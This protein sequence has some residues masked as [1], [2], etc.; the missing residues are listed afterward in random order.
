MKEAASE[1][2]EVIV[3][4][5]SESDKENSKAAPLV[6]ERDEDDVPLIQLRRSARTN[7]G[8]RPVSP[9]VIRNTKTPRGRKQKAAVPLK[10][11]KV[12]V[13]YY[14]FYCFN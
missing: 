11:E 12:R 1:E 9:L 7:K 2:G 8:K 4:Q 10:P 13:I 3:K 6:D 5:S 14:I